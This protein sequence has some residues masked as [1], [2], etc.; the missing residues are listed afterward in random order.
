[1]AGC[2]WLC[3]WQDGTAACPHLIGSGSR[4][5]DS[6]IYDF[7][8]HFYTAP[9][10]WMVAP[11]FRTSVSSLANTL[12]RHLHRHSGCILQVILNSASLVIVINHL[13]VSQ[14]SFFFFSLFLFFACLCL[15]VCLLACFE[16]GSHCVTCPRIY[17]V[18]QTVLELKR[19]YLPLLPR[20]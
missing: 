19:T 11:M 20:G 8:F 6:G 9:S 12:R 18:D 3:R 16:I 17:Y 15:F 2:R 4:D 5:R 7:F 10:K 1:M 14:F 13:R